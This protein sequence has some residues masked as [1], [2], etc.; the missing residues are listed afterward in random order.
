MKATWRVMLEAAREEAL[1]AVDLY[2]QPRRPRRLEGFLVH[3]HIAWLYLLQ[4]EFNRDHIDFHYRLDNGR[5]ERIDGE[6][7]AW[8][9]ARCA[10]ERWVQSGPVRKNLELSIALRNKVEHRFAEAI[11]LATSGYAQALLLNFEEEVTSAFDPKF[12]LGEQLRFPIF[13]GAITGIG[14]ARLEELRESLP[15]TTRDFLARFEADLDSSITSD[16]RYEFR[17][18][19]VPKL[20]PRM[21]ADR[22]LTFV[23]ETDLTEEQKTVLKDLGRTGSVVVREQVRQ[24]SGAGLMLPGAATTRIQERIPFRFKIHHFVLAYRK[25]QCRPKV[26][27]PRPERTDERHCFYNEPHKDYLYTPAFV[28]KVVRETST[29]GRFSK[30][31]GVEAH[32]KTATT[33]RD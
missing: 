18:H 13:V 17:M 29:A 28:A 21:A 27:D 12:S 26:G 31:L 6:P 33:E 25:V 16:Q 15:K 20:G 2:N 1:L 32:P 22:A 9:L 7:K 30:F 19:L 4:A 10:Q 11:T 23:R 24:V 14:A 3:M 8:D 5:F